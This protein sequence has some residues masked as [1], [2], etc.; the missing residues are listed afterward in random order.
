MNWPFELHSRSLELLPLFM[1]RGG[2]LEVWTE[3]ATGIHSCSPKVT[4]TGG[5]LQM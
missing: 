2:S 4:I 1:K 5:G 3:G